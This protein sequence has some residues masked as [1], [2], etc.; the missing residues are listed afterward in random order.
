[1]EFAMMGYQSGFQPKL[2]YH[3]INLEQRVPQDHILRKIEEK[4]DFGFIYAQ[5]RDSYGDNGKKETR[6]Q[7]YTGCCPNHPSEDIASCHS[8]KPSGDSFLRSGH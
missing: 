7:T 4:I 3:Q 1:M 2:F 5:V 6:G 8:Q